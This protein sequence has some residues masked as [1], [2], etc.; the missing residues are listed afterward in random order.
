MPAK[1]STPGFT[2]DLGDNGREGWSAYING[3]L[4]G[5]GGRPG[6]LASAASANGGVTPSVLLDGD[7]TLEPGLLAVDWKGYPVRVKQ[8]LN[9]TDA[10]LDPCID[11]VRARETMGRAVCH[12]EYLEW[13]TVR[14][15]DGKIMRVEFTTE[16]PD[17]WARLARFEPSK[18]VELAARF[19]GEAPSQIDIRELFGTTLDPF[20]IDP[21]S[22]KGAE[23]E[24]A[25]RQQNWSS[26]GRIRGAYNNGT[27][28]MMHMAI[29]ANSTNAAVALAVFAAFPHGKRV[30][31]D[32]VPLSGAEAI[33]GTAQSA[34]T[35]RN[36]DPTIVGVVIESVFAGAKVALMEA[37][38]LYILTE[39]EA[40]GLTF[41]DGSPVPSSW[42]SRQ[43]GSD[44][45]SNPVQTDL[46]QRLVI[47]APP[48]SS[49][50]VSDLLD[51]NGKAI[52]SGTQI[53]RHLNVALYARKTADTAGAQRLLIQAP[54]VPPCKGNHD[55][56]DVFKDLWE[57]YA[58]ASAPAPQFAMLR[59]GNA[60]A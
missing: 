32:E 20:T 13:R 26:G 7:P 45:H 40:I 37:I 23:L 10:K 50:T 21:F 42:I 59:G 58:V 30:G 12:E 19:S 11:W 47:E 22:A 35:C 31:A 34:V 14:R 39:P 4:N 6:V 46:F 43:R 2:T 53:A 49:Q 15:S 52:T 24:R 54:Q 17:Y 25:Y 56:T 18:V 57:R 9:K 29:S 38:G 33:L 16:T 1:I 5:G 51:P 44:K 36:S 8:T 60:I 48:G 41:A 27:K 55:S 3:I 28:A